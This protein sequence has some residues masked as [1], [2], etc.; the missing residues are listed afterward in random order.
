MEGCGVKKGSKVRFTRD[1][2]GGLHGVGSRRE[3]T[4]KPEVRFVQ[5]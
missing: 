2:D 4:G 3:E 5:G 1:S